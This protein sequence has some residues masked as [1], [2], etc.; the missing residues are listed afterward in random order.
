VS[1]RGRLRILHAAPYLW[2]GAGNVITRLIDSQLERH[3]I[4]LVT[5]PA[6]GDLRNWPDYERR[7]VK[8]GIR[9]DRIDLFHRD[10]DTFWPAIAALTRT[11][12][13]FK[14]DIIHTHAGTPTAIAALARDASGHPSTPL[15]SHFYSWG[16]GRPEWMNRMDFWAFTRAATVVC[17]A[18]AYR[19]ILIEGGVAARRLRVIPWGIATAAGT[20]RNE[21]PSGEPVIGTLGRI[22]R[23][24]GQL[25]LVQAFSRLRARWP[26][27]RLEI[28]GPVAE[29]SYAAE[30][31]SEIERLKLAGA[32]LLTG[33][34][35]DPVAYL[36]RWS[37]YVSLSSDEGQG[38]A[39]LEAM[40]SGVPVVA[41][42]VAGVEDYL[43][44]GRTGLTARTRS[45]RE[46]AGHIDRLLSQP[47][48]ASKLSA[49]AVAMVRRRYSWERTV[50]HI[51]AIYG[52]LL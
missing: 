16:L 18:K 24:K 13:A 1:K 48:L 52:Q 32:V 42:G 31:Q 37:A 20:V 27:A 28:V 11:I 38:L 22:E 19:S 40:V 44:N 3:R 4:A 9:H 23:R 17:S 39:V 51:D 41:L 36:T 10:G 15:V 5:S 26:N 21:R 47:A 43:T 50:E 7:I 49:A 2:S 45:P 29:E 14:P 12:D 46:V 30:V 8:S 34:V 35:A 25:D 33:H 6:S